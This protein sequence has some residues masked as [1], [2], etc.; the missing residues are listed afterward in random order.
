MNNNAKQPQMHVKYS[1]HALLQ[2][3]KERG[4][5]EQNPLSKK[6]AL[7]SVEKYLTEKGLLNDYDYTRNKSGFKRWENNL[8]FYFI[9]LAKGGFTHRERGQWWI[10]EKGRGLADHDP[11]TVYER[12]D[13]AYKEWDNARKSLIP[14]VVEDGV[15][16]N[17]DAY[18]AEGVLDDAQG[19][20]LR[21]IEGRLKTLDPYQ[22]QDLVADVLTAVGWVVHH[23]APR[24]PDGGVDI[25]A[26]M[27]VLGVQQ[28][29]LRVQ[30]KHMLKSGQKTSSPEV[31]A[32]RGAIDQQNESGM[33]VSSSGFTSDAIKSADKQ[34]PKVVLVDI[35]RLLDLLEEHYEKLP[36]RGQQLLPLKKV[37]FFAG[38]G[39]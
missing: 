15:V 5:D 30:V 8:Q 14:D 22:F 25:T 16:T 9:G 27:D 38:D 35:D 17:E 32:L 31:Q 19:E 29:R 7:S 3:L 37:Y 6:E 39:E 10:T 23:V 18:N 1:M 20:A 21:G 13:N 34:S 33:L 24:G 12:A 26:T 36:S 28:P 11:D 2:V 4:A